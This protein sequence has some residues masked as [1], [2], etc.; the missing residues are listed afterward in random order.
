VGRGGG[1]V[2][3]GRGLGWSIV[4]AGRVK[5]GRIVKEHQ[6]LNVYIYVC[7]FIH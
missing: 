6:R 3:K 1:R 5:V 7:T 4:R 2:W